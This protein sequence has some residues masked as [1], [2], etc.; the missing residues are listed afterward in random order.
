MERR[1]AETERIETERIR[2]HERRVMQAL[3][4]ASPRGCIVSRHCLQ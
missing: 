3:H 4:H 1:D 2:R